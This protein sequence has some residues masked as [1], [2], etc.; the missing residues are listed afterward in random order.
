MANKRNVEAYEKA[1][2]H[3]LDAGIELMH[4]KSFAA[5]GINE[6]LEASGVPKGSFYHY[7]RSKE[8]F[9]V[10]VAE[11]YHGKQLAQARTVLRDE[12]LEPLERL[13]AWFAGN[14]AALRACEFRNGCLMSNFSNELADSHPCFQDVLQRHWAEFGAEMRACI[15][16]IGTERLGL[17]HLSPA[18]AGDWLLNAWSGSLARMKTQGNDDALMLFE[19]SV[20]GNT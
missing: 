11:H 12:S 13:R 10:Q 1:K 16:Q 8:D 5:V 7:F 9:G 2:Q 6:I 15:E 14:R 4:S 3:L 17:S 18:E 20:F 19:K